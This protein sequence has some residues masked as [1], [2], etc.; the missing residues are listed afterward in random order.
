MCCHPTN[1]L[2]FEVLLTLQDHD[3]IDMRIDDPMQR[4]RLLSGIEVL[5]VWCAPSPT[6]MPCLRD[7]LPSISRS[8]G[9]PPICAAISHVCYHLPYVL[10]S[11]TQGRGALAAVGRAPRERL[12]RDRYRLGAEVN[13]G[14]HPAVLAVDCRTDLKVVVKFVPTMT[15]YHRQVSLHKELKAEPIA[16]MADSYAAQRTAPSGGGELQ[17]SLIHI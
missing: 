17:L 12:F 16:Q 13:F 6:R 1:E 15:D 11:P 4:M 7:V 9:L 10:P 2:D 14:G 3:L 5:K 8:D